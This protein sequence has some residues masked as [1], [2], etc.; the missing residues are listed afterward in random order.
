[1]LNATAGTHVVLSMAQLNALKLLTGPAATAV[2]Q[3]SAVIQNGQAQQQDQELSLPGQTDVQTHGP[4]IPAHQMTASPFQQLSLDRRK[5]WDEPHLDRHVL[6]DSAG[7]EQ[8]P[9][10]HRQFSLELTTYASI[11][12]RNTQSGFRPPHRSVSLPPRLFNCPSDCA[13]ADCKSVFLPQAAFAT[14]VH[15][16]LPG[17]ALPCLHTD[18]L[19]MSTS[20]APAVHATGQNI[21]FFRDSHVYKLLCVCFLYRYKVIDYG[22]AD[23]EARYAAGMIGDAAEHGTQSAPKEETFR[24]R[25][26]REREAEQNPGGYARRT[27]ALRKNVIPSVSITSQHKQNTWDYMLCAKASARKIVILTASFTLPKKQSS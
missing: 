21:S 16:V 7:N 8:A 26:Q 6:R 3:P 4:Q 11:P 15:L 20:H 13:L 14:L 9:G 10:A 27:L 1:M 22:L 24:Q 25:K 19:L 2:A 17:L 18:V 12:V 5:S 23:F